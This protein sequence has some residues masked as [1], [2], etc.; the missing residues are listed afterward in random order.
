MLVLSPAVAAAVAAAA[1]VD[2]ISILPYRM[3][4][5]SWSCVAMVTGNASHPAR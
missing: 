2:V 1:V 4:V 3:G 5:A